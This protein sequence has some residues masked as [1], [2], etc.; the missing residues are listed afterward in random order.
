MSEANHTLFSRN[1]FIPILGVLLAVA[2][3]SAMDATGLAAF[4]ALPLMPLT[5]LL[6]W[7]ERIP[8][9]KMG[10]A[11]GT[12]RGYGVAVFYPIAV[13]GILF[14]IC[15]ATGDLDWSKTDWKKASINVLLIAVSTV[16]VGIVTEEGFFR[17]WLWA[18]LEKRLP[19]KGK[20]LLWTSLC[21]ALWHVSAVV[22]KTGLDLPPG[23]IPLF[24]INVAVIGGIWG[25]LREMSH[26]IIVSSVSHGVW[27]GMAYVLFGYGTKVGALGIKNTPLYG[28]EVGLIGLVLNVAFLLILLRSRRHRSLSL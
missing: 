13:M 18:S 1:W 6:W 24:I 20:V 19:E 14:L 2:I 28:P 5:L 7:I 11:W 10:F 17:G 22:L 3:T 16:L 23:R 21:F 9:R 26:S 25:C 8:R 12:L 15:A 4:S 27:N